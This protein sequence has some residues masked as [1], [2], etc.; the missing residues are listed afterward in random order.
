MERDYQ[1]SDDHT[2]D[3]QNGGPTKT[4]KKYSKLE[5][6]LSAAEKQDNANEEIVKQLK[7]FN[8]QE[9][10]PISEKLEEK[11][12]TLLKLLLFLR[13]VQSVCRREGKTEEKSIFLF[14]QE[15]DRDHFGVFQR[16]FR[17]RRFQKS[18]QRF[19]F[20]P[21]WATRQNQKKAMDEHNQNERGY[22]SCS[23]P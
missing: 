18:C 8:R 21:F 7:S 15:V 6:Q 4:K 20:S 1:N 17:C 14:G 19:D 22:R 9:T 5:L 2:E 13:N 23:L 12:L 16:N 10:I 3:L 11:G